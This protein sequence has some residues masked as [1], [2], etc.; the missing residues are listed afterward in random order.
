MKESQHIYTDQSK[1][2]KKTTFGLFYPLYNKIL[3]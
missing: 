1:K 2:N 3:K